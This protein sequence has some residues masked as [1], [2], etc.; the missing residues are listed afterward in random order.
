MRHPVYGMIS[1]K[2]KLNDF[3][4][5]LVFKIVLFL[6]FIIGTIISMY[7]GLPFPFILIMCII[8]TATTLII[9]SNDFS[10]A[11]SVLLLGFISIYAYNKNIHYNGVA[12][13]YFVFVVYAIMLF[14]FSVI[15]ESRYS[16]EIDNIVKQTTF[17]IKKKYGKT[18]ESK[19]IRKII[20]QKTKN[21]QF[22]ILEKAKILNLL[23]R[24][25][26]I[27]LNEESI[28]KSFD[29]IEYYRMQYSLNLVECVNAFI[30][31]KSENN[32]KEI[33]AT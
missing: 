14:S 5:K 2:N 31:E 25:H 22:T 30:D 20:S 24:K 16:I 32:K 7:F 3:F 6:I 33:H 26:K 21:N 4:R 18:M 10:E 19:I 1:F 12:I 9:Y 11:F 27:S 28:L 8:I 17:Q 23:I 15:K 13:D 29:K